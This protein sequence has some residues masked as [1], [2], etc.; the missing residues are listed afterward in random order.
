MAFTTSGK[1]YLTLTIIICIIIFPIIGYSY[2]SYSNDAVCKLNY[3]IAY[4]MVSF[5]ISVIIGSV[6]Y[7]FGILTFTEC[8]VVN[9][10]VN[11]NLAFS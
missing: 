5:I 1:I 9:S 7:I 4:F 10:V 2:A 3:V 11:S 6:L 8:E